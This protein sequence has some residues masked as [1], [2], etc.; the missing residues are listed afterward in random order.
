MRD[1]LSPVSSLPVPANHH[2]GCM[3]VVLFVGLEIAESVRDGK[4]NAATTEGFDD[5]DE[6]CGNRGD[7][8][9]SR[10]TMKEGDEGIG[11]GGDLMR[12]HRWG[13]HDLDGIL[14]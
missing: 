4:V 3:G 12:L 13:Q 9:I 2:H 11:T 7:E 6:A 10:G 8:G 5:D 1:D 14:R